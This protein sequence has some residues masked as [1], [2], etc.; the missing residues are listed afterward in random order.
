MHSSSTDYREN[1]RLCLEL[2]KRAANPEHAQILR[3]IA[4]AWISATAGWVG[5]MTGAS[6]KNAVKRS[7]RG[8]H[9]GIGNRMA[10]ATFLKQECQ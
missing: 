1:A 7:I 2:A 5:S 4:K 10:R 3:K 8:P 9:S 6:R